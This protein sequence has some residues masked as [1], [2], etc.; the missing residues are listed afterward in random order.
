M[1]LRLCHSS[2]V[3]YRSRMR[4]RR[5]LA[6]LLAMPLL[7]I[8]GACVG[9]DPEL[10]TIEAGR[11]ASIDSAQA[12][13]E[14]AATARCDTRKEFGAPVKLSV[15]NS[16]LDDRYPRLAPDELTLWFSSKRNGSFDIF[17]A[18][19]TRFDAPWNSPTSVAGL[20]HSD[21]DGLAPSVTSDES[22][23]F[24]ET[25]AALSGV[26]Q[27]RALDVKISPS[28]YT[29]RSAIVGLSTSGVAEYHPFVTPKGDAIVFPRCSPTAAR[30][31]TSI[32]QRARRTSSPRERS[33]S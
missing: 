4:R 11:D 12:P 29:T 21:V 15:I 33:P 24:A 28:P 8:P 5:T 3:V 2:S 25:P 9:D 16:G 7:G 13:S 19:R 27:D 22:V 14:D 10:S 20:D 6:L 26:V 1:G 32:A 18:T 31:S 23:V 17:K 30:T